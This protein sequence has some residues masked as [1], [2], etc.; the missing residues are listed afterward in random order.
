M[1]EAEN[2]LRQQLKH[3]Y[4]EGESIEMAAIVMEHLTGQNRL[5]RLAQ[6]EAH[7]QE[8]QLQLLNEI[9]QRL[10]KN[11]PVQYILGEAYFGPLKLFVDTSV[12]IP[13]PET[14][15]LVRW[16]VEDVKAQGKP[17]F[18]PNGN[19]ADKTTL[20]KILDVGTGSGCIA[21]ALKK[22]MPKAEVWGCDISDDVLNIARRNGSELDIRIDFIGVNFLDESQTKQLPT[23]DI[24][25]SNPPYIPF[26]NKEEMQPNVVSYEPHE[27]LF[28]PDDDALVFYS[29]LAA[30][31][32]HRLYKNGSIYAE[33]H[34]ELGKQATELFQKEGY[35]IELRKDMQ[36]KERMIK[37]KRP[38]SDVPR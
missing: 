38:P 12:L 29:A 16:V 19:E 33:I 1:G 21:L 27:E 35:T 6:K 9:N 22:A 7:L 3:H 13:R 28:V 5:Q 23:V 36:G 10:Q 14:E 20:L 8:Q 4:D 37:V 24:I 11:E 30:F 32:K 2:W 26:K 25:V 15:E 34:E 31:G 18:Q 17:V